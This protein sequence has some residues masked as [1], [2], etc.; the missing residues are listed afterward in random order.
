MKKT[1]MIIKK[2]VL[3]A[4]LFCST[5]GISQ[6]RPAK[7]PCKILTA[8]FNMLTGNA[9]IYTFSYNGSRITS[10]QSTKE[11]IVFT[12]DGM[13]YLIKTEKI[14]LKNNS[15]YIT[16]DFTNNTQGKLID[17]KRTIGT[18]KEWFTY[19]YNATGKL[20]D[21]I[22]KTFSNIMYQLVSSYKLNWTG[23][24][25]TEVVKHNGAGTPICWTNY[26]YDTSRTNKFNKDFAFFT[27]AEFFLSIESTAKYLSENEILSIK[28]PCQ[29]ATTF[30]NTNRVFN[31]SG[32]PMNTD[33]LVLPTYLQFTYDCN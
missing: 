4:I 8:T 1:M 2:I 16:M 11:K 30:M 9:M 21:V 24:N 14:D 33:F 23:N 17:Q 15:V 28:D 12:F 32:Y 13:G 18:T 5:T 29:G 20:T 7:P 3:A 27:N 22:Y 26:T 6:G 19:Q 31:Q 25:V 10:M